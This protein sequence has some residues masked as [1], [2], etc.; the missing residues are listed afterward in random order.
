M[1]SLTR[2]ETRKKKQL[3]DAYSD[4]WNNIKFRRG[5]QK[6]L[7]TR[8]EVLH[9]LD[10]AAEIVIRKRTE[11]DENGEFKMRMVDGAAR[12][13][14]WSVTEH[15]MNPTDK[16]KEDKFVHDLVHATFKDANG[17]VEGQTKEDLDDFI[18][19]I[20][21]EL[22]DS[23]P[24]TTRIPQTLNR[25]RAISELLSNEEIMKKV[26]ND[27]KNSNLLENFD[28][29]LIQAEE[30]AI[31]FS[32]IFHSFQQ[33]E[34][35]SSKDQISSEEDEEEE[36]EILDKAVESL[37]ESGANI[38][39]INSSTDNI[40]NGPIIEDV[41]DDNYDSDQNNDNNVVN[42]SQVEETTA[43][44]NDIVDD[45][46]NNQEE[47]EKQK[48]IEIQNEIEL[49]KQKERELQKQEAEQRR[50]LFERAEKK[51]KLEEIENLEKQ[52][53][54]KWKRLKYEPRIDVSERADGFLITGYLSKMSKDDLE[55]KVDQSELTLTINGFL[56]PS[57][58]EE[59]NLKNQLLQ[60]ISY[61]YGRNYAA[62]I[63]DEQ[64]EDLLLRSG[65][66]SYG[67]FSEAY[68]LP[69]YVDFD[70]IQS[71]YEGGALRIAIPVTRRHRT[72][73]QTYRSPS[74]YDSDYFGPSF[75]TQPRSRR[76]FF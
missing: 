50:K 57:K 13:F 29:L 19:Q 35:E 15:P 67:A 70:N 22:N 33:I 7:F 12:E 63:D 39:V 26:M 41:S 37:R 8:E 62:S 47:I 54:S 34:K 44:D 74:S 55:V 30:K 45:A 72:P 64:L 3:I 36:H 69:E 5:W 43:T 46:N 59:L 61:R 4:F 66:G 52:R 27:E 42:P 14:L 21:H 68:S 24:I 49:Q 25:L 11:I 38:P 56:Y 65:S 18:Y 73:R 48:E 28:H 60:T 31:E 32:K 76:G 9:L 23:L 6:P 10:R 75:F 58:E 40:D 16:I 1:R 51:K 53:I 2:E 71:S 20:E 17:Y